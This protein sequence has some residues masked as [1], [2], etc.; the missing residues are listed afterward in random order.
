MADTERGAIDCIGFSPARRRESG[1][2]CRR[3][4]AGF[5]LGA[6]R[7]IELSIAWTVTGRGGRRN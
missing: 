2:A 7:L 3:G 6:P 5:T 4:Y 1:A